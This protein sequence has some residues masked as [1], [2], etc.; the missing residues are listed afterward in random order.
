[1]VNKET[2]KQIVDYLDGKG[3]LPKGYSHYNQDKQED[4]N[5]SNRKAKKSKNTNPAR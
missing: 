3:E 4:K 2:L 1:M 5:G